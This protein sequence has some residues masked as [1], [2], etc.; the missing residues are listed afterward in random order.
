MNKEEIASWRLII[1][2]LIDFGLYDLL[3]DEVTKVASALKR[4]DKE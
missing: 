1:K 3:Q 4:L 2:T